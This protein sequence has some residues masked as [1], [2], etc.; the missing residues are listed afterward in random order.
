MLFRWFLFEVS[1]RKVAVMPACCGIFVWGQSGFKA[2]SAR[3]GVGDLPSVGHPLVIGTLFV[4]EGSVE[5]HADVGH[6]VDTNC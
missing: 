5:D 3:S 4:G 2:H 1:V 6:G